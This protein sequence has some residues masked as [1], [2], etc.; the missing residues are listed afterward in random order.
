MLIDL[1]AINGLFFLYSLLGLNSEFL[2]SKIT[3]LITTLTL[4]LLG[5]LLGLYDSLTRFFNF[6]ELKRYVLLL[7]LFSAILVLIDS[8]ASFERWFFV[9]FSFISATIPYRFFIKQ[10]NSNSIQSAAKSALLYGAGEQ[11]VYLKRSFFNSPHFVIVGFID[12]D[13]A[14]QGRKIDGVYVFSLGEKLDRFIKKNNVGHVIFS[15]AK[16]SANRKQFLVEHFKS[17]QIQTYNLP[18]SDVWINKMPSAAQL[19]KIR[20]EDV[21]AR[22]EIDIDQKANSHNY[23]GK[24]ILITGG[25]G[26]IG[27]ELLRQ[28]IKF[29]ISKITVIDI[30]ETALFYLK[31][32]IKSTSNVELLLLNVLDSSRLKELYER[33]QFDYVF[34]AAAYKHV[35]VVEDNAIQGLKNNIIGTFN[36]AQLAI[37]NGVKQFVLVS[38]DKAVRPT[39]VMGASKRY[40][41]L[42]INT[43]SRDENVQT[44]FI[45]TRF[46][47]VLGSNGSVI[48]IFR[49]QIEQ[50][51][52][53]TLTHPDITRY[54]M[55]IPEASKLVIESGR[56]G[57]NNQVYV[58]DMGEPVKIIDMAKNMISLS[59]FRPYEDID[60][61]IVGLRPGEKLFEELLLDTET[62]VKSIHSHLFIAQKE[63][64]TQEQCALIEELIAKLEDTSKCEAFEV[65]GLLKQI[66]PEYKS[67]NSPF[68]ALDRA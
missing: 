24:K 56:I 3:L 17:R 19:K 33:E 21:L 61:E 25:A 6:F 30:N 49:S 22:P 36:V 48:P 26:S 38:T 62:M 68:E 11:G 51:G 60:I 43:L 14:L 8:S 35:S 64:I 5:R 42:L 58:F 15:T 41:E 45:T 57:E 39:S 53:I 46:G 32:E 37:Q 18:S 9:F 16:F 13:K 50:G 40:C 4:V 2:V 28:L 10:L 34:H 55:T 31:G 20:I 23:A 67:N 52:P 63:S 44:K 1:V 29:E 59:G 47:N 7:F 54:F 27:S 66:I 12:D 65:I